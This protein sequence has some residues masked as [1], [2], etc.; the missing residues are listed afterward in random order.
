MGNSSSSSSAPD[1][2]NLPG[3]VRTIETHLGELKV[4]VIGKE[5][6][7]KI[8]VICFHGAKISL[9]H[10]WIT[11]GSRVAE[12]NYVVVIINFHSNPKTVPAVLAHN[13]GLDPEDLSK[14]VSDSILKGMFNA[15][16]G[17]MMGKSWG[18]FQASAYTAA[19][20][21]KVI[22]LV[23]QAPAFTTKDRVRA[24]AP[25][26]VPLLLCWAKDDSSMWYSNSKTWMAGYEEGLIT[27]YTAEK[28]GHAL[29]DEYG[30]PI[31]K[32]LG[33]TD[34]SRDN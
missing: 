5:G 19:N 31:L 30:D 28:G 11:I 16:K 12:G 1:E 20:P 8:P 34:T 17:I 15:E 29:T 21:D 7:G 13:M 23:L 10:E 32:F 27:L 24:V 6:E 26:K 22:K 33:V 25:G 9:L 2:T 3:E 18:G 14:I 4:R